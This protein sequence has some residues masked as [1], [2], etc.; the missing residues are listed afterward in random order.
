MDNPAGWDP[1]SP[2][3]CPCRVS[4]ALKALIPMG[5]ALV[6]CAVLA[7]MMAVNPTYNR[8]IRPF[9][10]TAPEGAVGRTRAMS[11]QFVALNTADRLR[12][13]YFGKAVTRDT[14]G[15]FLIAEVV[16]EA[17]QTSTK[18]RASWQG[19]SGRIYD[20]TT[21]VTNLNGQLSDQWAQPGLTVRAFAVFE[22]PQDEISGGALL[23]GLP[24]DPP[25]DG[26]LRLMPPAGTI[27]HSAERELG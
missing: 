26:K 4:R 10:E 11:A 15:V 14:E 17:T 3:S 5:I 18:L 16:I 27:P 24:L 25:L 2:P 23:L 21:R 1:R 8:A 12:F 7:G 22:L 19:A 20:E 13:T 6:G 9:V